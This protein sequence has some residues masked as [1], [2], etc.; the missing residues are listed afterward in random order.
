MTQQVPIFN[1][2]YNNESKTIKTQDVSIS[3]LNN[4]ELEKPKIKI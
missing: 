2:I 3:K 4:L 1:S